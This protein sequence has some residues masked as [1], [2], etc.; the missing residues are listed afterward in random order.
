MIAFVRRAG[1]ES[2]IVAAG[3][4]FTMLEIAPDSFPAGAVWSDTKVMLPPDLAPRRYVDLFTGSAVDLRA[5]KGTAVLSMGEA[6]AR[7]PIS[8][9]VPS[10]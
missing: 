10:E 2:A 3:R 5:D 8:M 9:L 1:R 7:M 6:F 4:F